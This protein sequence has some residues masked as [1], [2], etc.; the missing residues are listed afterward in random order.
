M[1]AKKTGKPGLP[2]GYEVF[3]NGGR[4]AMGLDA[5]E[6]AKRAESLGAGEICVNSIDADGTKDGYELALTRLVSEAVDIPVIAS[7]G[8]GT[9]AHLVDVFREGKADAGLVA[10]MVHYGTYTVQSIKADLARAGIPV[11]SPD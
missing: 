10:S 3:I 1:D 9:P 5:I 6:W 7:G 8:A 2:S 11:R 4:R